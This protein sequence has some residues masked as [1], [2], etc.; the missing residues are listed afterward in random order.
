MKTVGVIAEYNPFH[1][2]HLYHLQEAKKRS[3]ADCAAVVMSGNFTQRGE[4]ALIGKYARAESALKGGADLVLELPLSFS[5][6]SAER[7]ALGG[8]SILSRLCRVLSFGAEEDDPALYFLAAEFISSEEGR[9]VIRENLRRGISYPA[10]LEKAAALS[11]PPAAKA[12]FSH[13]NAI[14]GI[15]YAKAIRKLASPLSILPVA[16]IGALHDA[17]G[18]SDGYSASGIRKLEPGAAAALLP[19]ESGKILLREAKAGRYM[20]DKSLF[21]AEMTAFLR[22]LSARD[23]EKVAGVSEGLENRVME[24][25]KKTADP[26]EAVRLANSARYPSSRVRRILLA[27]YL[28][29]TSERAASFPEPRYVRA[30][31][32]NEKGRSLLGKL[33]EE[34]FPVITNGS[35]ARSRLSPTLF[36]E[37]QSEALADDLYYMGL[38]DSAERLSGTAFLQKPVVLS[39]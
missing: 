8:V 19:E 20:R 9:K 1:K 38:P 14:L 36:E 31:A 16:R 2:G 5:L 39:L 30:L 32:F 21:Y 18:D 22:R 29:L 4:P 34:G 6:A 23:W 13:P 10:A 37:F 26:E 17:E 15:E 28:G 24:A 11:L 7:F 25:V 3:G 27:A 35:K 12:L 33:R